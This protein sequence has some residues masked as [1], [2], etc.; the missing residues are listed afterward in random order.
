M[1]TGD[2]RRA[3]KEGSAGGLAEETRRADLAARMARYYFGFFFVSG[4]CS[5]VYQVAW[6]RLAMARFGVNAPVVAIVVSLF[7]AG[8]GGGSFLA[9]RVSS[10]L[11]SQQSAVPARL[12]AACE[13]AIAFSALLVP[14]LLE[15]GRAILDDALPVLAWGSLAYYGAVGFFLAL[16]LLPWCACMGATT[17]L[18]MAAIKGFSHVGSQRMFSYLYLA[19]VIGAAAGTLITAFILIELV[20]LTGTLWLAAALNFGI[21]A[22]V[23]VLSVASKPLGEASHL[24]ALISPPYA[25]KRANSLLWL[26]LTTGLTSMAMEL[27][28]I[29]LFTPYL[30][31]VVYAFAGV[32]AIY[33]AATALGTVVYRARARLGRIPSDRRILSVGAFYGLLPLLAADPRLPL[34]GGVFGWA[35]LR[36]LLGIAPF[37]IILGFLTPSLIDRWSGGEPARA[38]AAYAIN[39]V[40]SILGP[41]LAGFLLLP[42]V[43]E[44][45]ALVVLVLPLFAGSLLGVLG[46]PGESTQRTDMSDG[47]F[48]GAAVLASLLVLVSAKSYGDLFAAKQVLR[49]YEATA[50]AAGEG[51]RKQLLVNGYGMTLLTTDTKLMAHLPLAYLDSPPERALVIAFGM[52]TTF[53]SA[54][55]WGIPT[56]VVDLV[57]SVPELFGYFHHDANQVSNSPFATIVIDDGR[58]FL[59][60]TSERYDVIIIDPPPPA[61]AIG[62]SLLYSAEFYGTARGSLSQ[63]GILAQWLVGDAGA[64]TKSSIAKALKYAFPHVAAF[65]SIDGWGY[66]LLASNKPLPQASA[67]KLVNRMPSSAVA[68]L[69]EWGP[70]R[71]PETQMQDVLDG[72]ITLQRLIDQAPEMPMVRDTR[73]VNEYFYLRENVPWLWSFWLNCCVELEH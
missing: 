64:A 30:G 31:N 66:H 65:R 11:R 41:L 61:S 29:R 72:E 47:S 2:A 57:P 46:S 59:K 60:R 25:G 17:P 49:D 26:L 58:R 33:L 37:C 51:M 44:R 15:W 3:V 32:L 38:G 7:M 50:I 62:S 14:L 1:K 48:C 35:L 20:G 40:G 54:L 39:I 19:N 68:D 9:G 42:R 21:S 24:P 34:A 23:F 5:L 43:D 12:Y 16:V 8:L 4:F 27:V 70:Y 36:V 53:R 18:A 6:L 55:S 45:L 28:W 22:T 63:D 52:G 67:S 56:T 73:P 69:I 13:L 71:I 10:R